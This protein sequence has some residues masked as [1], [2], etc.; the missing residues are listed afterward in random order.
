MHVYLSSSLVSGFSNIKYTI[1]HP[2]KFERLNTAVFAGALQII[3]HLVIEIVAIIVLMAT[4]SPK[5]IVL[6]FFTLIIIAKFDD[7]F[8]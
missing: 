2:W 5:E 4:N 8:Y 6:N 3:V 1:N 7:F